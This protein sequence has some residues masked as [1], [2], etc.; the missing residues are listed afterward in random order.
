MSICQRISKVIALTSVS[1]EGVCSAGWSTV[2]T[3]TL[4][5]HTH[6]GPSCWFVLPWKTSCLA[7]W[8]QSYETL[9]VFPTLHTYSHYYLS[10]LRETAADCFMDFLQLSIHFNTNYFQRSVSQSCWKS[11][12]FPT[13][14]GLALSLQSLCARRKLDITAFNLKADAAKSKG[15]QL[16]GVF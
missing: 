13:P 6:A 14:T 5:A 2:C 8:L 9:S 16:W 15:M 7:L 10:Q 3:H 4:L 12:F 11:F 1:G